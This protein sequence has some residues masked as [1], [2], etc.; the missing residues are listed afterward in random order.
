MLCI[1]IGTL[2]A[3]KLAH[4]EHSK[5]PI[6]GD[7]GFLEGHK[8]SALMPSQVIIKIFKKESMVM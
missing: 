2:R 5:V 4:L 3:Y 6:A 7:T 8:Q 1:P